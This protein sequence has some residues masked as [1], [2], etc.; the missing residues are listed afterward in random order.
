MYLIFFIRDELL[1]SLAIAGTMFVIFEVGG[2]VGRIVW[3]TISD[4]SLKGS[5]FAV[6]MVIIIIACMGS[7]MMAFRSI[8][9]S[10]WLLI[11]CFYVRIYRL[12]I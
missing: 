2:S 7:A 8:N 11:T 5:R 9:T 10:I 3:G 4:T 1:F 6:M 12:W